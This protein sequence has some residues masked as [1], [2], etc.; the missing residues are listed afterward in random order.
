MMDAVTN[1]RKRTILQFLWTCKTEI[2]RILTEYKIDAIFFSY[3]P[4]KE[5]VAI[6]ILAGNIWWI[7]PKATELSFCH[8]TESL[9]V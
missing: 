6:S 3:Q 4:L 5:V 8:T 9:S 7:G 2:F 1:L